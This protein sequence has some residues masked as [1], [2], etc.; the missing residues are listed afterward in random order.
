MSKIQFAFDVSLYGETQK[1]S[2]TLSQGR[3]RI[4]YKGLNRN[5]T[6]ITDEFAEKLL[7]SLPYAPIV[8]KYEDGDFSDHSHG[9][10]LQVY[11]VIPAEPNIKWEKHLDDDGVEREYA[12]ADVLLWTARFPEAASIMSKSQSMEIWPKSV[13]G[14][15]VHSNGTR[16]FKF[17][18][19]SFLGLTALGDNVEPCFEG[20]AFYSL[21]ES[22]DEFIKELNIYNKTNGGQKTMEFKFKLSDSE[23]RCAI[24]SLINSDIEN[25]YA[26][27][28]VCDVY[29]DYALCYSYAEGKYFRAYYTKN[30]TTDTVELTNK[31]DAYVLDLIQ[32][33]YDIVQ[34]LRGEFSSFEA[35]DENLNAYTELKENATTAETEFKAQKEEFE[36]QKTEFENK[37]IE[38]ENQISELKNKIATYVAEEQNSAEAKEKY[39]QQISDLKEQLGVLEKYQ[40]DNENR[41]KGAYL[42]KF[43]K[44]LPEEIVKNLKDKLADF[45][46]ED[47]EK[48]VS[49]EVTKA[50]ESSLLND[51]QQQEV[52]PT[53]YN[54]DDLSNLTPG[55]KLFAQHLQ[56]KS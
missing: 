4:F 20:A 10:Q 6:F 8:G 30:D 9:E 26:D 53:G 38:L 50:N 44:K 25:G 16:Y 23:K 5:R 29:D 54:W 13:K 14:S 12:C 18:E 27:S 36:N 49:Y 19:G 1:F 41:I 33:E 11:G 46:T 24:F 47:F 56:K 45:S 42:S 32:S 2:P 52:I 7:S 40:I 43:S 31:E 28:F 55:Q 21:K 37:K 39:E 3:V 17:T 15:W 51:N 35:I 48:E 22:I 34:K